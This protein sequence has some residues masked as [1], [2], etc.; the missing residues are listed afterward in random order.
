MSSVEPQSING[1]AAPETGYRLSPDLVR[2]IVAAAEQSNNERAR[3]LIAPLH[4]A[5]VADLIDQITTEQRQALLGCLRGE[6]DPEILTELDESVRDEVLHFLAPQEVAEAVT[7]LD[8]D[9]AVELLED[10]NEDEQREVLAAVPTEERAAVEAGLRYAEDSAGRLMQ[11]D[12]VAVPQYWNVGKIIDYL[13]DSDDLPDEFF[14]IFVIDPGHHPV[15]TVPLSRAMRSK[16]PVVVADIMDHEPKII[17]VDTDQEDVAYVFSQYDLAS[18]PVI[19]ADSRIVGVIMVDD[20]V[21]VINEENEGDLMRLGGVQQDDLYT[22]VVRTTRTRFSWLAVNLLTAIAASCVIA[23]FDATIEEIVALAVL[24]PIVA[25]MGGNAGTQTLTVAVRALATRELTPTNAVRLI[26]KEALVG[27]LN[28]VLFAVLIG[29]VATLWFGNPQ[30]GL[31]LAA[32][33]VINLVVAGLCGILI[34]LGLDR[35]GVDPALA[36]TVF[37]TTITDVVGFFAFL[38]LAAWLLL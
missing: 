4:V 24:M 17:P 30:L 10:L 26:T 36:A 9:D 6:I 1:V 19:D 13:R 7:E 3:M 23:L 31:V 14:E 34:P 27:V 32:A 18:A 8:T 11:R 5:D 15:G 28:G 20:V 22:S 33:M 25:S 2:D 38:G 37:L 21:D 35:A 12:F 16:R 29:V